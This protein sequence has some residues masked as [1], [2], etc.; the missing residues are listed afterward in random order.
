MKYTKIPESTFSDLQL[1]AG[2]LLTS[3]SPAT[4][5]VDA[6]AIIGATSGGVSITA[7]PSFTDYGEDIDNCPK[8]MK[9]LKKLES[10]EIKASGT[11]VSANGSLVKML[12]SAADYTGSDGK[13]TLRNDL[14]D[15]DFSDLWWVGDYSDK[16]GDKN[17][18]F[19]ACHMSNALSTGGFSLQS[20]DKAKGQFAFEF[21]AHY[22]IEAQDTVPFEVYVVDGKDEADAA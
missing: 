3:F 2:V 6:S 17:G 11:F 4:A 20:G 19:I 5:T 21:T 7:V 16:N 10:W 9:E 8:N 12:A 1:N 13:V 18:G 22:S 14:D 15:E